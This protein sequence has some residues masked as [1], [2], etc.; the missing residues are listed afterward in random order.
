MEME[1]YLSSGVELPLAL[2]TALLLQ[3][4]YR[5]FDTCTY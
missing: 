5:M 3:N 1:S 4:Q 2:P